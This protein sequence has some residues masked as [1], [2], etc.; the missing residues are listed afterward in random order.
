MK[1]NICYTCNS[2]DDISFPPPSIYSLHRIFI[3]MNFPVIVY[4]QVGHYIPWLFSESGRWITD[5]LNYRFIAF[6]S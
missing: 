4:E 3:W 5:V 1:Q 2:E 6:Q